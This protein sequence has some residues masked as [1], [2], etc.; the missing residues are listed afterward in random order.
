MFQREEYLCRVCNKRFPTSDAKDGYSLGFKE[1]FLCPFCNANLKEAGQ[2][3]DLDHLE[4]GYTFAVLTVIV[5]SIS[6]R[7]WWILDWFEN[8]LLNEIVSGFIFWLPILTIFTVINLDAFFGVRTV[9]TVKVR[10]SQ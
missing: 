5:F 9:Y 8:T 6:T 1:G 2:S 4:Y 3:D 10:P 7:G